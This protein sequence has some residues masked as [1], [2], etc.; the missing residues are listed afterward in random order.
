M[1]I[2]QDSE[3]NEILSDLTSGDYINIIPQA[4]E[5]HFYTLLADL[6]TYTDALNSTDDIDEFIAA[7]EALT[8]EAKADEP[9]AQQL[10]DEYA[11]YNADI[12]SHINSIHVAVEDQRITLGI[13]I[14]DPRGMHV[15][16]LE[17]VN[18]ALRLNVPHEYNSMKHTPLKMLSPGYME[19]TNVEREN[20][21]GI[22]GSAY[23]QANKA[24][25]VFEQT[26]S[27]GQTQV[28]YSE[29]DG[30]TTVKSLVELYVE[31]GHQLSMGESIG[32][33]ICSRIKAAIQELKT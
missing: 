25:D 30:I 16:Q 13:S 12:E 6:E 4:D 18:G 7:F 8:E 9:D 33:A 28:L 22:F 3:G 29:R 5:N 32:G 15:M 17:L 2:I 24:I 1:Y 27:V 23:R 31:L 26:H 10:Y 11:A 20:A 19:I 21:V 14:A